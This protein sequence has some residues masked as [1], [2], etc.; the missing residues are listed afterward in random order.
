M[1]VQVYMD[2]APAWIGRAH[3]DARF[4]S[5]GGEVI[6]PEASPG[7]CVDHD[8]VRRADLAFYST[9]ARRLARSPAAL[10]VD[11]WSEPH[12]VNWATPTWIANPEFCF[13][14]N[15]LRRFRSWLQRKYGSLEA[16]D[17]AWYRH[18]PRGTRS[19]PAG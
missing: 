12:V 8:A 11:L 18:T 13:C 1:I 6:Q 15:T 16:L 17:A 3:P 14:A 7:Y 2:S 10:G 4:V 19:S 5:S 9:V